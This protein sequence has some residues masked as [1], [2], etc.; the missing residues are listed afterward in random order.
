[1]RGGRVAAVAGIVLLSL[2]VVGAVGYTVV[3]VNGADRD[4]GDAVWTFPKASSEKAESGAKPTGLAAALVPY[5]PDD[6]WSQGPDIAQ[7]GHDTAFTG[8]QATALRKE[9]LKDLP[10]K[11]RKPLEKAID[12]QHTKG[13]AMRSYVSTN[14]QATGYTDKASTVDIVLAQIETHGGG[15]ERVPLPERVPRRPRRLPGRPED[16]GL[17]ERRVLPLAEGP[18]GKARHDLL[19][20]LPGRSPRLPHGGIL[21]AD[22]DLRHRPPAQR[23]TRPHQGPGEAV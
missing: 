23:T 10:L 11:Q 17:Q 20:R 8:A 4:A 15:T 21:Q 16:Q 6:G 22:A 18:R 14:Q 13:L 1:M 19:L 7:Y 3:T 2:A 5:T 9:A 12:K